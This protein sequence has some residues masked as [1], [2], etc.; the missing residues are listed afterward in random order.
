MKSLM[1]AALCVFVTLSC[2][3]ARAASNQEAKL[4]DAMIELSKGNEDGYRRS[5]LRLCEKGDLDAQL[6]YGKFLIAKREYAEAERWLVQAAK[7]E[8]SES[9]YMLGF[10]YLQAV[11]A[12]LDKAKQLFEQASKKGHARATAVLQMFDRKPR[13]GP[14]GKTSV[15]DILEGAAAMGRIKMDDTPQ[16]D[17]QCAGHTPESYRT[18]VESAYGVCLAEVHKANGDWVPSDQAKA[19]GMQWAQ[20]TNRQVI[21]AGGTSYQAF[22][23]CRWPKG[24]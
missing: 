7:S 2:P 9:Q 8:T 4:S 18:A 6:A 22:M 3:V 19:V 20:C 21:A 23:Q 10:L 24:G 1:A 16:R 15:L 14:P 17:M 5:I 13:P 11:P 12:R